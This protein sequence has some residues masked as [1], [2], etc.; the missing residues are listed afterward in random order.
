MAVIVCIIEDTWPA[1]IDTARTHLP[2]STAAGRAYLDLP[3]T[4]QWTNHDTAT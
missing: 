1:C 2:E 4:R 3:L